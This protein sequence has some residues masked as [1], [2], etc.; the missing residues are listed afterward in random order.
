MKLKKML[1]S[2]GMLGVLGLITAGCGETSSSKNA[3][4]ATSISSQSSSTNQPQINASS[5]SSVSQQTSNSTQNNNQ[6]SKTSSSNS[7]SQATNISPETV[8]VL[9]A[10]WKSPDWFKGGLEGGSMYY[11][12]NWKYGDEKTKG[13]NFITAKGDPTSYIYYKQN[14]DDVIVKYVDPKE[15]E[16]VAEAS[17]TSKE[18]SLKGLLRD[19]YTTKDQQAE[20]NDYVSKL[21]PYKD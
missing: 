10:L 14:G 3:S 20:V 6:D 16:A 11:G 19:Y 9:V 1:V 13:Y 4:P 8:G 5:E 12:D 21:K 18:V 7:T 17:I 2:A 15:G